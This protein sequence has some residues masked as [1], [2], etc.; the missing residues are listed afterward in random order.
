MP[1]E[2]RWE[3]KRKVD[4]LFE[5]QDGG[6]PVS[7]GLYRLMDGLELV[8]EIVDAIDEELEQALVGYFGSQFK[9]YSISFYRTL[10]TEIPPQSSFL[11][12]VDNV[13]TGEIKLMVY[14]DDVKADTGA[15]RIKRRATTQ[16]LF[17]KG[18]RD[19][20][21]M[22]GAT[23]AVEDESTTTV[24]EGGPATR[25]LFENGACL[26]KATFPERDHRDVVTFVIIPSDVPWRVNFVRN[27]HLLSTNAGIC[28]D[29][30]SDTPENVGYQY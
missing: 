11:W 13:P 3:L 21:S 20:W 5:A 15:F 2:A 4:R 29:P 8:P 9:I 7:K 23:E 6:Y 1:E 22:T 16:D 18:Y 14:L 12:H 17:A 26:H 24:I 28:L 10:P 30:F 27:R 19:R 25:I